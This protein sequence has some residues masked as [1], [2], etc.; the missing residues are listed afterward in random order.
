MRRTRP[1]AAASIA[2]VHRATVKATGQRVAVKVRRPGIER[3]VAADCRLVCGGTWLLSLLPG[4]RRLP[5]NE[6]VGEVAAALVAQTDFVREADNLRRYRGSGARP[7]EVTVPAVTERLCTPDVLTME[8]VP[9]RGRITE[10]TLDPAARRAAVRHGLR[11]IYRSI[12]E[13]GFFHCDPHPGNLLVAADGSVV[14]LDLGYVGAMAPA[15][16]RAFAEFFLSI[17]LQDAPRAARIVR[18]TALRVPAGMDRRAFEADLSELIRSC[19]GRRVGDF[20]IAR[21]VTRLFRVQ[22]V[23]GILGSPRFT[24]A[25]LTLLAFEGTIKATDPQLDFQAEAVP[26]ILAALAR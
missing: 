17:A 13:D 24:L 19:A 3:V 8:Y 26:S 21:F 11:A 14:V 18:E 7:G 15:D 10:P 1:L 12:F 22:Q 20:Q 25:I 23:H 9:S 6:S 2:Q 16:R 4:F 5:L